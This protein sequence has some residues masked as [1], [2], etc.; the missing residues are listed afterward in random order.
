MIQT[1]NER[2]NNQ[3]IC[4]YT[5]P[6]MHAFRCYINKSVSF[7]KPTFQNRRLIKIWIVIINFPPFTDRI[8]E[9]NACL[10]EENL[11]FVFH[12]HNFVLKNLYLTEETSYRYYRWFLVVFPLFMFFEWMSFFQSNHFLCLNSLVLHK[13]TK[14]MLL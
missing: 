14:E 3:Q 2:I 6:C 8:S 4:L 9:E 10:K 5:H 11:H 1:R 7:R 13:I 12:N